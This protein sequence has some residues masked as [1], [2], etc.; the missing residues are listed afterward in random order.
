MVIL[1]FE[2]IL[3]MLLLITALSVDSFATG[4]AYGVSKTRIPILSVTITTL[5]SSLMLII[6]LLAGN[7]LQSLIPA[8]LTCVISFLILFILGSIKLFDRSDHTE[9]DGANKNGDDL[10]SPSEAVSLGMA[11]SLD[12]IAAGIGAG[13]MAINIPAA[14][15]I[16]LFLGAA[17]ILFGRKLGYIIS[18]RFR[19]NLSWVSGFLLILLAVMKLL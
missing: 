14:F 8:S 9:A 11:L 18:G 16:S 5:I 4:F 12:S 3:E 2:M 10:L 15:I 7:F 6:S 19:S 1:M 13:V 17:A